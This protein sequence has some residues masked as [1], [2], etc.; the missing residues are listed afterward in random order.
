MPSALSRGVHDWS[1]E[2]PSRAYHHCHRYPNYQMTYYYHRGPFPTIPLPTSQPKPHTAP[3]CALGGKMR[4]ISSRS[5][6]SRL[7]RI[8]RREYTRPSL[9]VYFA[10]ARS[11][12]KQRTATG[13][14]RMAAAAGLPCGVVAAAAAARV[15]SS[16]A[17]RK[18]WMLTWMSARALGL[19]SWWR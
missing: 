16:R 13:A 19:V 14:A 9:S 7:A 18:S 6:L 15:R 3:F 12:A 11:E 10:S 8:S 4:A 1:V 5:G 17:S 2:V